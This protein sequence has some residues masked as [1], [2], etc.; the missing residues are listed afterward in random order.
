[1]VGAQY[2]PLFPFFE[3]KAEDGCFRVLGA[4]FVTTDAGTGVV[5]CAPGFGEDDYAACVE[6]KFIEPGHAP[7]PIDQDGCFTDVISAYKGIYVKEADKQI[8]ADVK[9][10]GRLFASGTVQHEY[11]FCWRSQTPL[12]YR[13]FDCWFIKV[14]EVKDRLIELNKTNKWVPT[15]VQEKRF[16]N[17]LADV[18]DW[19]FSRNRYWGNPIPIWISDDGEEVVCV[20][21]IKELQE[22]SGCGD[23]TDIHKEFVDD[24][25]IPSKQGK[26]MLKRIPEVF[27]CWFESGSMP[28][29][30]S[31]YPFSISEEDFSKR[32][33]ADF[34]AE[35]L[36]QTRGWFYTLMVISGAVKDVAPFKNLIVNGIVLAEDGTK[37]SKSKKNYPDPML[38]AN[39]Y[40]ADACR[41]YLCNSPVMRA[42]KLAFKEQGV[43]A[44][45]RDVFLPWYNAYRFCIQNISRWETS[46]GTNFVFE[47]QMRYDIFSDKDANFMD[48]YI[49]ATCQNMIKSVRKEMDIYHLYSVVRHTLTFLENLTNWYVRLNRG[50][51]KGESDAADPIKDQQIALNTLFDV[52]LSATQLMAPIT[53]FMSEFLYQNMRNGLPEGSELNQESIHFTMIPDFD[54]SLI[55]PVTEA[56]VGRMQSAIETGRKLRDKVKLPM[57]YPLRTVKLI[58][59]DPVIAQGLEDLS[60]YIKT[61]L[62]CMEI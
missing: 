42:E 61:E 56:K 10:D 19:C 9:A 15:F 5:H 39:N 32:F 33:P 23:L 2:K 38:I 40:G 8:I 16:H 14:P 48:R 50:R 34:I 46:T 49:I 20:G 28:F 13:A 44:I 26:G 36:D 3:S 51:M 41:L 17:W 59:A 55:D 12:L 18:K 29:A 11:P 60:Y 37:M 24:I 45:V 43:Q 54:E 25:Q 62:N 7:V 35:G 27:D 47:P 57:K 22:L 30:Q 21:S 1:M 58:E 52:L 53:P 31:H 4:D 6:N